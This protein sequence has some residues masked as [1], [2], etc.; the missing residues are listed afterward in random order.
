V[1]SGRLFKTKGGAAIYFGLFGSKFLFINA[2]LSAGEGRE[3]EDQRI[4][5]L[6]KIITTMEKSEEHEHYDGVFLC[7]DLNFR[8]SQHRRADIYEHIRKCNFT[9]LIDTDQLTRLF[10]GSTSKAMKGFQEAAFIT[11]R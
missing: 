5:E 1:R 2:H 9:P 4:E 10:L 3:R 6:Y 11:F 7:G 8:I